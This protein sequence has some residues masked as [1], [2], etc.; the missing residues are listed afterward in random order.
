MYASSPSSEGSRSQSVDS[1]DSCIQEN[2]TQRFFAINIYVGPIRF[3]RIILP[4]SSTW[5]P[6]RFSLPVIRI[7]RQLSKEVKKLTLSNI[8]CLLFP[9][10]T[11]C[12]SQNL[13][14][15]LWWPPPFLIRL[16]LV[17]PST[18]PGHLDTWSQPGHHLDTW[19]QLAPSS[20]EEVIGKLLPGSA[21]SRL[22]ISF[23]SAHA[24]LPNTGAF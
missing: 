21:L 3:L 20:Q 15:H 4:L 1:S 8:Y 14:S 11:T 6:S 22:L 2:I 16:L 13:F 7:S 23:T 24:R 9:K 5:L 10:N 19:R 12:V 17:V 18:Q